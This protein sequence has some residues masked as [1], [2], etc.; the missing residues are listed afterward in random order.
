MSH[1]HLPRQVRV[2]GR[3]ALAGR[4]RE[5]RAASSRVVPSRDASSGP[6]LT[7]PLAARLPRRPGAA[8]PG[9]GR[10]RPLPPEPTGRLSRPPPSCRSSAPQPHARSPAEPRGPRRDAQEGG[11]GRWPT[12]PRRS[13]R[14]GARAAVA[15]GGGWGGWV[16]L[17]RARRRRCR[18]S[19]LLRPRR[20][21]P[22]FGPSTPAPERPWAAW[23][24]R[25]RVRQSRTR[26]PHP[27]G[28]GKRGRGRRGPAGT[29]RD[30]SAGLRQP[31][32]DCEVLCGSRPEGSP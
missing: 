31:C 26:V 2:A 29:L 16:C 32:G 15:R 1:S 22:A 23:G 9:A 20:L 24:S 13:S 3:F 30:G 7:L 11:A 27:D 18:L 10:G 5:P 25:C 4:R 6:A 19:L 14:A 12:G 17:G 28:P 21:L 8:E